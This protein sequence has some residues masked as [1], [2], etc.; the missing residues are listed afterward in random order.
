MKKVL[1]AFFGE[2]REFE[3]V[4]PYLKDLDKVDII[5]STWNTSSKGTEVN[6]E[7][8]KR[9]IPNVKQIHI[10]DSSI[11]PL[12][13]IT[14]QTNTNRLFYHWKTIINNLENRNDYDN[15]IF[16]RCDLI[17]NWNTIL[18]EVI[19]EDTIYLHTTDDLYAT[20]KKHPT[21][22]WCNDYYFY[23]DVAIVN[24]FINSFDYGSSDSH[25]AIFQVLHDNNI[26]YKTH[27]LKGILQKDLEFWLTGIDEFI[28]T[29][30]LPNIDGW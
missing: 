26:K 2:L 16:H 4:I 5:V 23:G 11:I 27:I 3:Q 22:H 15:I 21:A 7:L 29:S 13:Q 14:H 20:S 30:Q 25:H 28:N 6:E 17:S 24:K 1:L 19:E 12:S 18:D 10:T 9:L 8:I